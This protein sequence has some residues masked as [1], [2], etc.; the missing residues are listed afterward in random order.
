MLYTYH[1]VALVDGSTRIAAA[2]AEWV[3]G[4]A[5]QAARAA[6][7]D[8]LGLFLPQLGFQAHERILLL[9]WRDTAGDVLAACSYVGSVVTD[10]LRPTARPA[11][12]DQLRPGGI[13][14]HRWFTIDPKDEEAFVA[15]SREAWVG[16]E[17][18]FA[19]SPFG[20][21]AA[22]PKAEDGASMRMLLMTRY[23][24]HADWE[25]SRRPS[26]D[27]AEAF[28]RRRALTLATGAWSTVAAALPSFAPS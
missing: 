17:S 6:G 20:L 8:L 27:V 14:V 1:R 21:F 3:D 11:D 18:E 25:V 2:F 7:G 19:S 15:L 24:G 28:A 26:A 13:V 10:R 12:T 5:R 9:R 4:T 23:D 22:E 16:F